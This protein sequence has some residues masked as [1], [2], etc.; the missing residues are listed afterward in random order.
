ML[1][2][3]DFWFGC[4]AS[5]ILFKLGQ[6]FVKISG[7]ILVKINS[8]TVEGVGRRKYKALKA[9]GGSDP[10]GSGATGTSFKKNGR[11]PAAS[12]MDTKKRRFMKP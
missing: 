4:L 6:S 1:Q 2:T 10:R 11:W 5:V 8:Q 9:P 12:L 3:Y 7:Q